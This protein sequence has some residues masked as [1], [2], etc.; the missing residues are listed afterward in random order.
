VTPEVLSA[1]VQR[2][3]TE[4]PPDP[5]WPPVF[6]EETYELEQWEVAIGVRFGLL[7]VD[8]HA[9]SVLRSQQPK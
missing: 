4:K 5:P 9:T 8:H 6:S 2:L 1:L 3:R 7:E